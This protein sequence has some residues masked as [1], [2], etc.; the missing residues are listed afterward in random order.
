MYIV[1]FENH[2]YATPETQRPQSG[3]NGFHQRSEKN[4]YTSTLPIAVNDICDKQAQALNESVHEY[5]AP[6]TRKAQD[7]SNPSEPVYAAP[8]RGARRSASTSGQCSLQQQQ[9]GEESD[10]NNHHY[11]VLEQHNS[12]S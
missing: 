6:L 8:D 3:P 11:H 7:D 5:E 4:T 2:T 12:F 9:S 10:P 1:E